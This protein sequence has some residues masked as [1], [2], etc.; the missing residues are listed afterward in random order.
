M[1][2]VRPVTVRTEWCNRARNPMPDYLAWI[3][4]RLMATHHVLLL[5]DLEAGV[6]DLVG[7]LPPHHTALLHG[8]LS[9]MQAIELVRKADV[10][11]GGVG[12]IVPA[13]L[14]C[15]TKAVIVLGGNGACNAPERITDPC[16]PGLDRLRFIRPDSLCGCHRMDHLCNKT[17]SNLPAQWSSIM[18]TLLS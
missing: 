13:S 8:E 18:A 12:W 9:A 6:E 10:V 16:V 17:I 2:V 1:A 11:V 5:A 4:E 3:A 7:E 15:G 14:A